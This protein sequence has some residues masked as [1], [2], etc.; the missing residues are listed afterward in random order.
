[1]SPHDDLLPTVYPSLTN[2]IFEGFIC[3]ELGPNESV[4]VVDYAINCNDDEYTAVLLLCSV[5]VVVWP[6][7]LPAFM[8][9]LLWDAQEGIQNDDKVALQQFDFMIGDYTKTHWYW[10]IAGASS[11]KGTAFPLCFYTVRV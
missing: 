3:R 8:L 9:K 11:S 5:L 2:K 7:G 10:E 4:L 1:M 6:F